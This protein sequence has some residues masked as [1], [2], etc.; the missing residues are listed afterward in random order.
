M[1][2]A[3][4]NILYFSLE[5]VNMGSRTAGDWMGLGA[6]LDTGEE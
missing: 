3:W 1:Y 5:F 2:I 4:H 6:D